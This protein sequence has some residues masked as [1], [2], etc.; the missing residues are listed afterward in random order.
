MEQQARQLAPGLVPQ[1]CSHLHQPNQVIRLTYG[2]RPH[3]ADRLASYL[4]SPIAVCSVGARSIQRFLSNGGPLGLPPQH[5][6]CHRPPMPSP[7][8]HHKWQPLLRPRNRTQLSFVMNTGMNSHY[9]NCP[10]TGCSRC[11]TCIMMRAWLSPL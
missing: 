6:S 11:Q 4:G 3:S 9:S 8:I 1:V 5:S 7:R 10:H 2:S